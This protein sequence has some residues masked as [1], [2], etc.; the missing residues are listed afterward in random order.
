MILGLGL[1]AL[2]SS[3]RS[4]ALT[5]ATRALGLKGFG[6]VIINTQLKPDHGIGLLRPWRSA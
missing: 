1:L 3:R 2:R 4:N 5:R 6:H